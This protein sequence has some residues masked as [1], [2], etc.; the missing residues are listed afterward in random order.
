MIHPDGR[1]D[2]QIPVGEV[3]WFSFL[4]ASRLVTSEKGG[5]NSKRHWV[6]RGLDKLAPDGMAAPFIARWTR[7]S[8]EPEAAPYPRANDFQIA[9]RLDA[10]RRNT[11]GRAGSPKKES[12][13]ELNWNLSRWIDDRCGVQ[14]DPKRKRVAT[15]ELPLAAESTGQLKADVVV[16]DRCGLVEIVELKRSAS[17]SPDN[18]LLALVEGTCYALQLLRCWSK[19]APC[20]QAETSGSW[21][22]PIQTISIVLAAPD[23]WDCCKHARRPGGE[24]KIVEKE[25]RAFGAIVGSVETAIRE[26]LELRKFMVKVTLAKLIDGGKAGLEAIDVEGVNNAFSDESVFLL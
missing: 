14:V 1:L 9:L 19:L 15:Y 25:T 13:N 7:N 26:R 10:L 3:T 20:L 6:K 24:C 22:R 23:Y 21:P 8:L 12:E 2:V 4:A 18:P 11:R 16:F 17:E 5:W